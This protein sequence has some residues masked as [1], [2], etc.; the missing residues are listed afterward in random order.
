MTK[1]EL[2]EALKDIPDDAVI[3]IYDLERFNHPIWRLNTESYFDYDNGIP[4]VT[5]ETNFED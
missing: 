4:I 3:D 2:F 5:I 1:A